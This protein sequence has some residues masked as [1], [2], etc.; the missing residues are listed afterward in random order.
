MENS[1]CEFYIPV[2]EKFEMRGDIII[3]LEQV[4]E[5]LEEMEKMK[6]AKNS[7]KA[8]KEDEANK[9]Q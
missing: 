3:L 1:D 2:M 6:Q 5:K 9:E 8:N 7:A 4:V